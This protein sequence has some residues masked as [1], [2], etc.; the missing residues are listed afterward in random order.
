MPMSN[1]KQ[2]YDELVLSRSWD[3]ATQIQFFMEYAKEYQL[4]AHFLSYLA[5]KGSSVNKP[6]IS[7]DDYTVEQIIEMLSQSHVISVLIKEKA[8][9]TQA[10][11]PWGMTDMMECIAKGISVAIELEN[12]PLVT[13]LLAYF[14]VKHSFLVRSYNKTQVV[15]P[16]SVSDKY[17]F[18]ARG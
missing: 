18:G 2:Q 12:K 5:L 4:S 7:S 6:V 17:R 3:K 16:D 10:E 13:E 15:E 11:D 8:M 1:A 14:N 9:L